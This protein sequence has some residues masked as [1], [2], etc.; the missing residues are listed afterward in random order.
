MS[1][2]PVQTS[3]KE[4]D[5][6]RTGEFNPLNDLLIAQVER[7][8]HM[9]DANLRALTSF[10]RAL[11]SIDGTV[12]KFIEAYTMEPVQVHLID[13][14]LH[15][16]EID[17]PW[18]EINAGTPVISRQVYLQGKYSGTLYAF[19]VS[20]LVHDQLPEIVREDLKVHPGGIGQVLIK[21]E[22]ETRREVLWYGR[23]QLDD[24]PEP[25]SS[26][27]NGR[28]VSRTYR[29]VCQGN[30]FMLINEKFPIRLSQ[31]MEHH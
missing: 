18:L 17:H 22:L 26:L 13:Q 16:L 21:N 24:L 7:P 12:T 2:L 29:V 9:L 28:F 10:Q 5:Y 19:A 25:I 1:V 15:S 8:A 4:P 30:P 3:G 31:V 27:S 11:L 23:E 14:D 6:V 20:L